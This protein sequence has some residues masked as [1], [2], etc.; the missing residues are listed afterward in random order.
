[1][2]RLIA[3]QTRQESQVA[4]QAIGLMSN[5]PMNVQKATTAE[6]NAVM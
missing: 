5:Q 6:M 3:N 2:L 1:L 4:I